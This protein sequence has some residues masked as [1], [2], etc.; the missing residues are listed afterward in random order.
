MPA[1]PVISTN[2]ATIV[3]TWTA[4]Y[5]GATE[6]TAYTIKIMTGDGI[7]FAIDSVNCNG[8]NP[9]IVAA[10]TCT[11]PVNVLRVSPFSIDWGS[12][13]WATVAA[14]NKVGH[15]ADSLPGNGAIMLTSPDAPLNVVNQPTVTTG[16]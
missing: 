6:I 8:T 1:A 7:T 5:N 2:Q 13:I 4:P 11:V 16:S 15:S 10:L 12:S 3:V 14:S 9:T